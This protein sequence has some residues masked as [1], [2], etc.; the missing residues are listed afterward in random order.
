MKLRRMFSQ[1]T[2]LIHP[3]GPYTHLLLCLVVFGCVWDHF[4]TAVNSVQNGLNWCSYCKI[5]YHEVAMEFF[6]MNGPSPTHWTLNSCFVAFLLFC[7]GCKFSAKWA[8]P[9][10]MNAK[11]RTT[12]SSPDFS[13][14][15]HPIHP[16]G[17]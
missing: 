6:T 2:H 17:H 8:D 5:L 13:Q 12:K 16:I 14:R 9:G 4:V 15:M 1:R 10:A 11:V 3:I 7:Y